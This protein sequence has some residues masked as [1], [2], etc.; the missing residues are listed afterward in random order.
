MMHPIRG[1]LRQLGAL[2]RRDET[3][4]DMD[5]EMRFHLQ[6]ETE[7]LE[8]EGWDPPA[9]KR[10]A[11]RR[12]GG[13]QRYKETVRSVRWTGVIED[14]VADVRFALRGMIKHPG[15]SSATAL[16][17]AL[18]IA[19]ALTIFAV[20]DAVLLR[21]LPYYEPDRVVEFHREL[22][23]GFRVDLFEASL[24]Q[25]AV[26]QLDVLDDVVL[27]GRLDMVMGQGDDPTMVRVYAA[28]PNLFTTL[29][30]TPT[31]GR[32][33][34]PSD[35]VPGATPVAVLS[36]SMWATLGS[37]PDIV[38]QDI[39]LDQSPY[40]VVGIMPLGFRFPAAYQAQVFLPLADDLTAGGMAQSRV[41][42]LGRLA[43][44][45]TPEQAGERAAVVVGQ[46]LSAR[47]D[48]VTWKASAEA[49][50][51][52]RANRSTKEALW[53]VAGAVA[54]ML[55]IAVVDGVNLLL[56]RL[57]AR[58]RELA[59]RHALGARRG[60]LLR[61]LLTESIVLATIAG[62]V[63][64]GL[65][66]AGVTFLNGVAPDALTVLAAHQISLD[67][68]VLLFGF[69]LT[70]VV[71]VTM[72]IVPA[73]IA[74]RNAR[75]ATLTAITPYGAGTRSRV[76]LRSALL[77][78][79]VALTMVLLSSAGLLGTSFL[80]L[81]QVDP[82]FDP[83]NLAFMQIDL[84]SRFYDNNDAKRS[85]AREVEA[86]LDAIPGVVEVT[87]AWTPLASGILISPSLQVEG[88]AEP[89][90]DGPMVLPS[91]MVREDY[92]PTIQARLVRGRNFLPTEDSN[93]DVAII[94]QD[95]ARFLWGTIDVL[96][97][98]FRTDTDEPWL[99]V[100][101]VLEE[102]ALDPPG[103]SYGEFAMLL[104]ADQ[105]PPVPA[106]SIRSEVP[107]GP[108]LPLIRDA[109]REVDPWQPVYRLETANAALADAVS[110]QRFFLLVVLTL[111]AVALVL[112]AAGLYGVLAVSVTQRRRELGIR[113]ALGARVESLQGMVLR[114]GLIMAGVGTALG[115]AGALLSGSVIESLL[116]GIEPNHP[117]TLLTVSLLMLLVAGA[118]S[119]LP[120]RRATRVDPAETLRT[121]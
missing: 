2:T 117:S 72:G 109:V 5:E 42:I 4:R 95:M 28:T 88:E 13:V 108:L 29:G 56:T 85:F 111:A 40:R 106:F 57:T 7:K 14:L 113:L 115:L 43:A 8:R 114:N 16:T 102:L 31:Q 27:H 68:R 24:A 34:L 12:F 74:I 93:A 77:V 81:T 94:D 35:A 92:L 3:E 59:V 9:A 15:F 63:A 58:G 6:M 73:W 1:W 38:G 104:A 18:G 53:M 26:E 54:V 66:S 80:R 32:G 49:L 71:G 36:H 70:L 47:G 50:G 23:N 84:N 82:G 86:R 11:L 89:R 69:G 45:V 10:E 78:A 110:D 65:A 98:R 67:Q 105:D 30:V 75:G 44:G 107:I 121:E 79:Q 25:D 19:A 46:L 100:V 83:E 33:I 99:T 87:R 91:A 61:H 20:L 17:L 41:N 112:A 76:K 60:R 62:L 97:K 116:F 101:G 64:V 48:S 39:E 118:A 103:R 119:F 90:S 55:L 22:G 52:W 37:D 96:G 120:A 51:T 21:P